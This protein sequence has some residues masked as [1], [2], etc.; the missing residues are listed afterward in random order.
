MLGGH[1]AREDDQTARPHGEV[2][3]GAPEVGSPKLGHPEA[4]TVRAVRTRALLED[5][6]PMSD[7]LHLG[8]RRSD[9]AIVEKQHRTVTTHEVLLQREDLPPETHRAL[10]EQ[11]DLRQRVEHHASRLHPLHLR[12]EHANDL[13]QSTSSVA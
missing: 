3:V 13:L 1:Q 12:E 6:D 4:A 9:H 7:A 10:C 11:A 8:V 2:V 5:D